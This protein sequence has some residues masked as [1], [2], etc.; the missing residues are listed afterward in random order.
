MIRYK[1]VSH[2][3]PVALGRRAHHHYQIYSTGS[4]S[5]DIQKLME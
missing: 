5:K 2:S 1:E 4:R 3:S